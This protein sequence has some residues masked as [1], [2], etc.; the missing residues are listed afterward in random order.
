MQRRPQKNGEEKGKKKELPVW[1]GVVTTKAAKAQALEAIKALIA[2]Q[3]IPLSRARMKLRILCPTNILKQAVKSAP[4]SG[5][6]EDADKVKATGTVKDQI[7]SYVEQVD[8]QDVVGDDWEA[9]CFIEPG[10]YRAITEFI[11]THTKGKARAEVLDMAVVH[12]D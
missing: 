2:H 11:G 6:G 4:K 1:T 9:I 5:A 8:S 10:A 3:P 7:L 12:E